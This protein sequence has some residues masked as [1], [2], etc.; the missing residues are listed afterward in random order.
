MRTRELIFPVCTLAFIF[1]LSLS[2]R[3]QQGG[4]ASAPS[5]NSAPSAAAQG[6]HGA[7]GTAMDADTPENDPAL[8]LTDSQK[9]AIEAIRV[10]VK[11]QLKALKK[12]TSLTDEQRQQKLKQI[13]METRK[14]VWAVMTPEQQ[15]IWA[16][17]Q[18]E[19]RLAK[20]SADGSGTTPQ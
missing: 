2:A 8:N 16:Q 17:E 3:T 7:G 19:R 20:H 18:R 5:P 6:G 4:G 12:D 14:Q 15:K 13:K 11:D 9:Q 10:D 1:G